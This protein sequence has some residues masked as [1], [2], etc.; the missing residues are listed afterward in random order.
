MQREHDLN[1]C[2]LI[3]GAVYPEQAVMK[4]NYLINNGKTYTGSVLFV[5]GFIKFFLNV[6][7]IGF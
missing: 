2:T 5:V 6:L 4:L 1:R 3:L 7:K